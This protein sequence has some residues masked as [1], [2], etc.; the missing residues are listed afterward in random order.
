MPASPSLSTPY[1]S[2]P[3]QA[4]PRHVCRSSPCLAKTRPAVSALVLKRRGSAGDAISL[5]LV[6][7][8]MATH[9]IVESGPPSE[10]DVR[11]LREAHDKKA[12]KLI[13]LSDLVTRVGRGEQ[14]KEVQDLI[15]QT[16]APKSE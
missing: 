5:A 6:G 11:V 13:Q 2:T 14:S 3:R 12:E 10:A 16:M 4:V 8:T 7:S 15:R 9:V 1:R